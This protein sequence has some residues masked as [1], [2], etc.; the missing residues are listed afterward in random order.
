MNAAILSIIALVHALSGLIYALFNA[1]DLYHWKHKID[2]TI[3][4]WCLMLSV[5][6]A[7]IAII[8]R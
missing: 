4:I 3:A 2:P 7:V 6:I 8:V 5:A 1:K